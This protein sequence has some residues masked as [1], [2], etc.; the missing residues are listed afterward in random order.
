MKRTNK[1]KTL[2][3]RQSLANDFGTTSRLGQSQHRLH[4]FLSGRN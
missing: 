4:I 1:N 2:T 3:I